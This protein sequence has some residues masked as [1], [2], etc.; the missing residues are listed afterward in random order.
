MDCPERHVAIRSRHLE[1]AGVSTAQLTD[2]MHV[3][4]SHAAAP[5]LSATV[6]DPIT[7]QNVNNWLRSCC[8]SVSAAATGRPNA[9]ARSAIWRAMVNRSPYDSL[10]GSRFSRLPSSRG[11]QAA[12]N[13]GVVTIVTSGRS[14]S[15]CCAYHSG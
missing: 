4:G 15:T 2:E 3:V 7:F 13:K 1:T 6:T 12:P 9:R 14:R 5:T 8:G 11:Y 10:T